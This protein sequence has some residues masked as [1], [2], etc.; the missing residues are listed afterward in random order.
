[1]EAFGQSCHQYRITSPQR[2]TLFYPRPP[3]ASFSNGAR[4]LNKVEGCNYPYC[5]SILWNFDRQHL[6]TLM[7]LV[8]VT[9]KIFSLATTYG[10]RF[11]SSSFPSNDT[12]NLGKSRYNA[13]NRNTVNFCSNNLVLTH[14]HLYYAILK[15]PAT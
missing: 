6:R 5:C 8:T 14:I 13:P 12:R 9:L 2:H 1:M 10:I 7:I 3:T 15:H 4:I 11:L